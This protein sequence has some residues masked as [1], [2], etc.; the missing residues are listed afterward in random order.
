VRVDNALI[1][2]NDLSCV[3][4][5]NL[6][7]TGLSFSL[8]SGQIG[9]LTGA[10]G[11]GKSSLMRL[12][13]G[14]LRPARG[15]IDTANSVALCD[16]KLALDEQ[17]S[18][19]DALLFW[20]RLDGAAPADVEK[21]IEAYGLSHLADVPISYFSTGQKQR[22]RLVRTAL[23]PASLWLLDEPANGLDTASLDRLGTVMKKHV[24]GGGAILAASHIDL[25]LAPDWTIDMRDYRP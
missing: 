20:A 5:H 17:A 1:K 22:A 21:A 10:N 14:L 15:Q 19:T 11:A 24:D 18:L 23:S 25:P 9:L 6:V 8:N 4:G 16:D 13:A 7:F 2:A 12:C 3:R